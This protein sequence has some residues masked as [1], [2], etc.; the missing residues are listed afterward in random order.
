MPMRLLSSDDNAQ[1]LAYLAPAPEANLF[2]TGDVASFGFDPPVRVYASELADGSW[3]G[4]LL[5]FSGAVSDYI[6]YSPNQEFDARQVAG[7]IRGDTGR[8]GMPFRLNGQLATVEKLAA[9]LGL[10]PARPM[11][12]ARL[13]QVDASSVHELPAGAVV[14]QI[15]PGEIDLVVDLLGTIDEFRHTYPNAEALARARERKLDDMTRGCITVGAF[16]PDGRLV[17]VASSAAAS[18]ESAMIVGV[19]TREGERGRGYA[20]AIVA[21]LCE[22]CLGGGMRFLCLFFE[23][24]RAAAIYHQLGFVDVDDYALAP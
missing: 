20:T 2:I 5:C 24:P 3:D 13:D 11:R 21:S 18:S 23:N 7:F 15:E 12:I 22:R 1:L 14:R 9:L 6:F 16:A 4:V 10:G 8:G 19:A 17:A